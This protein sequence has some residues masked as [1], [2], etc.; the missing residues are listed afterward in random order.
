MNELPFAVLGFVIGALIGGPA[1]G[2]VGAVIGA[3][4]GS[5]ATV[6][7]YPDPPEGMGSHGGSGGSW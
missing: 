5:R 1:G 3:I 6:V 4:V 2:F 7:D